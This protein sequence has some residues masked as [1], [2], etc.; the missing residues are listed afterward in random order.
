MTSKTADIVCL[1]AVAATLVA[2]WLLYGSLPDP[3]PSHWNL[4]GEVDG[5]MPR[6]WGAVILPLTIVFSWGL[7]AGIRW[8]TREH[9]QREN[10]WPALNAIQVATVLFMA[11]LSGLVLSAAMGSG[12]FVARLVPMGIGIVFIVVGSVI[13]SVE[14][15][16]YLGI[17][18]R[19][20]LA[21]EEVW[22]RTNRLGGRTFL[23]GGAVLIVASFNDSKMWGA[24]AI[25]AVIAIAGILPVVYSYQLSKRLGRDSL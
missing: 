9:E 2:T 1:I 25:V 8:F 3:M 22:K 16:R 19:W 10:L 14:Q 23:L 17:R 21:S 6:F 15:N 11:A 13:G 20:T 7:M 12:D 5:Y 4:S 18:T 24:L